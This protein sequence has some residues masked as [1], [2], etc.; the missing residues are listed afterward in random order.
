MPLSLKADHTDC[1][2]E[3]VS[4][5]LPTSLAGT[6]IR[7]HNHMFDINK[8]NRSWT[9]TKNHSE[10]EPKWLVVRHAEPKADQTV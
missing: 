8:L 1:G 2:R 10:R 4:Q 5:F 7:C 9:W 6:S 3:W